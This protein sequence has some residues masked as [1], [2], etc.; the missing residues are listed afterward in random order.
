MPMHW[1]TIV[2]V[3]VLVAIFFMNKQTKKGAK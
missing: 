1:L 3:V 2:L